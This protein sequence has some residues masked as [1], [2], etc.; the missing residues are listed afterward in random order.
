MKPTRITS[1]YTFFKKRTVLKPQPLVPVKP[2]QSIAKTPA[3]QI[4]LNSLKNLLPSHLIPSGS[5]LN[6]YLPDKWSLAWYLANSYLQIRDKSNSP[7]PPGGG[8]ENSPPNSNNPKSNSSLILTN[9]KSERE[10]NKSPLETPSLPNYSITGKYEP[11]SKHQPSFTLTAQRNK[12]KRTQRIKKS[13]PSKLAN[14]QSRQPLKRQTKRDKSF[15]TSPTPTLTLN[16]SKVLGIIGLGW[17][18]LLTGLIVK[19]LLKSKK[20]K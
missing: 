16:L 19:L 9:N 11:Q 1:P 5:K 4:M 12:P 6:S 8:N 18:L 13:R 7:T 2:S 3:N 14:N 20:R 10:T 17:L 15:I